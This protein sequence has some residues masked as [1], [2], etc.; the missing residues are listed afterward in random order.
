MTSLFRHLNPLGTRI[1]LLAVC[2]CIGG[3][4]A[5]ELPVSLPGEPSAEEI[6]DG[7]CVFPASPPIE[8]GEDLRGFDATRLTRVPAVGV[9]P[10][11]LF[12]PDDLPEIRRRVAAT[13]FGRSV[14]DAIRQRADAALRDP[15]AWSSSLYQALA[16]G[17]TPAA[18]KII[19]DRGGFPETPNAYQPWLYNLVLEA[20]DALLRDD[21]DAGRRAAT[22][23]ATY[24]ELIRPMVDQC[25]KAPLGE[26]VWRSRVS[27]PKTGSG[28]VRQGVREVLGGHL[29]GY[30]YD[31]SH[32][33]MT[34][35]QRTAVRGLIASATHGRIWMGARLPAHFRNWNWIAVGLQQPL[36]ALAIEGEEGYDPRVY[37]LGVRV[38]RDYLT[39]GISPSGS[40][41][42]AVGYTQFGLIWANPFMVA[43]ARRGDNLLG[44]SHHRAMLDW[45]LQSIEPSLDAF[46]SHGDGGDVPPALWTLAM[47][48]Y[49][50]P[51]DARAD[52]LWQ[53]HLANPAGRMFGSSVHLM[54]ALLWAS[55]PATDPSGKPVDYQDGS[56]LG[57]PLF[58]HDPVRGSVNA[59][60]AWHRDAASMQIECRV[61]SVGASHEHADRGNFT[62]FS[63]GR[64]WAKENF[65]SVETRHHNGILIDGM[66]QGYWPGPGRWIACEDRGDLVMASVDLADAYRW[67][68]PKQ[69]RAESADFIRFRHPRW[70]SYA[71]EAA[72]FRE[73]YRGLSIER[74][75]RPAVVD[76]WKGYEAS[77]PRLWDEDGWPVRL[78]HCAVERAF[79]TVVFARQGAPWLLVVDDIRKDNSE[80]LYEWLMQT[81]MDTE[82]AGLSGNDI[83]LTDASVRR[84]RLGRPDLAK[85][86]R[87]LL[88]R[89]LEVAEPADAHAFQARPS[90][91]LETFERRDS[92]EREAREGSLSGARSFGLDKR[93][94]IGSRSVEPGFKILLFP[95]RHGESLPVT[96]WDSPSGLLT[97]EA[98]GRTRLFSLRPDGTGRTRIEVR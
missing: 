73:T 52:F 81:G 92:L 14:H 57:A 61:D 35:A 7:K 26:D 62:F 11:L 53:R 74:D 56:K 19:D 83:L 21:A 8:V 3:T 46:T 37:Q 54:E 10:R 41:T 23:I 78:P 79:R 27:G 13:A 18:R 36:L 12:G 55:D 80:R 97:I 96:S 66:G 48:R 95:H 91:R 85:G 31:F 2:G 38:A 94:V 93:L 25:L 1:A 39:Y 86:D 24:A 50:F 43:A 51:S 33:Y 82:V 4:A 16:S 65:R 59:R 84:D 63:H 70:D 22:A 9:H 77:D 5:A 6:L 89:V 34:D 72:A 67:W 58:M 75:D 42:E 30:G 71:G 49:F 68:W 88:V 44:H 69:I 60:T 20:L 17:D 64:A 87:C 29:L 32:P 15:S 40:S 47:W 76:F 98:G 45:Y 28:V 90:F